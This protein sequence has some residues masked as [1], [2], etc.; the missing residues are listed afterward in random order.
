MT[1]M[2]SPA[3]TRRSVLQVMLAAVAPF[4]GRGGAAA[5]A[6]PRPNLLWLVSEDNNPFLGCYG[7][8]IARTPN[9]DALAA[10]GVRFRYAFSAA[11]VCAPS[12][13]A[14]LTG[15]HPESCAPANQMRAVATLPAGIRTYPE[16]LRDA[17]YY[18]TNNAKTD[19]N[20]AVDPSRIFDESSRTAHYRNRPAGAPFLAVFNHE[21]SHESSLMPVGTGA[22]TAAEKGRVR[23]HDVRLP[24]YLPDTPEIRADIA[25]YYDAIE[26]T[27]ALIGARL[28]ELDE[29][30]LAGDTI[31]FY[32][33]D[34]GGALPRS[35]R[36]CY[37]EGL[38]CPL[39][40]AFPPRW[41]HF[42]PSRMGTVI[43]SP[44]SLVDL[45]PTILSLAGTSPPAHMQGRALAGP[46]PAPPRRHAFGMRNRMDERYDFVRA[47]TD[48]RYHYVRN[49]TPH[50]TY[51]HGAY[52][53][54]AKGYQSWER[55][56]RAGRLNAVQARFFEGP[57]PFEELYDLEADR[58]QVRNL[59]GMPAHADRLAVLRRALDDHMIAINDNGFI[60]EG[61][62]LEGYQP[63]RD[64][65]AY[66]LPRVM[67]LAAKAA[68]REP[69]H[70][71]ALVEDLRD[72]NAIVRHWAAQ[73]LL[74]LGAAAAPAREALTAVM[75]GD[76]LP[77][78]VVVAA[79]ALAGLGSGSEAI[80][81]LAG[82]VD[83]TGPWQV[84]LQA[85]N[86]LTFVGESAK[87]ALPAIAR[88]AAGDQEYLRNAGRY[89]EVVLAGRYD[90]TYRVFD[91]PRR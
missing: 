13:F 10:R 6:R 75:R 63:S 88:A 18:C 81:V 26:A 12:R 41:A 42:A 3:A 31:V 66:P 79:E 54:Q 78:N 46:R 72:R 11:P 70:L 90:P 5:P 37:D 16:Y 86:A 68:A 47:A 61:M 28:R 44:V 4:A 45:P 73:G 32:Y 25:R 52:Q 1:V 51:Q 60:P 59:A 48:G 50:R 67:A 20:C 39:V 15:I 36:Y 34:N 53:W 35:K 2:M 77:Q 71:G 55:E 38:R 30:G 21:R 23:P 14:I 85:L 9:I 43:E 83:G 33:S 64:A 62:S 89:L 49:Y 24:A 69:G 84:K 22:A 58:D 17:G 19:H 82:I 76:A 74:M 87:A 40:I 57:R 29:A 65:A 80:A 91:P 27:D 56:W 8:P 7:D